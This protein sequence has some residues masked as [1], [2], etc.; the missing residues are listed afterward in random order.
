MDI[1]LWKFSN[2]ATHF[3]NDYKFVEF[4]TCTAQALE[5]PFAPPYL[6]P[7]ATFNKGVNFASGGS[8][9]FNT[10][11]VGLVRFHF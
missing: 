7:N 2:S 11:G 5:L 8:G 6:Q 10:T 4:L 9:L 3:L 1:E